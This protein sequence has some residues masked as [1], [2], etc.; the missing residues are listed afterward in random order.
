MKE[1][2]ERSGSLR[3]CGQAKGWKSKEPAPRS[4]PKASPKWIDG[5][6]ELPVF[7]NLKDSL[8][9]TLRPALQSPGQLFAMVPLLFLFLFLSFRA[10]LTACGSSQARGHIE[11]AAASLHHSHSHTRSQL[12]LRPTPQPAA[13][14]DP[15]P[16]EQGQGSNLC[17]HGYW[18]AS[19]LLSYDRNSNVTIF[20]AVLRDYG[21]LT[22]LMQQVQLSFHHSCRTM[23]TSA[24]FL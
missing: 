10:T 15:Q 9:S 16:T 20:D 7:S 23:L 2:E 18:S 3:A 17:P 19:L 8:K 1:R 4:L 6:Q 24:V 11:A 14:P 22:R 5:K 21:G 12:P 13:T